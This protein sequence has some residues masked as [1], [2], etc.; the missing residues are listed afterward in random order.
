MIGLYPWAA[1]A[2]AGKEPVGPPFPGPPF[3]FPAFGDKVIG[4]DVAYGSDLVTRFEEFA[5]VNPIFVGDIPSLVIACGRSMG[6]GPFALLF[7][8]PDSSQHQAMPMFI[9]DAQNVF[10][11]IPPGRAFPQTYVVYLFSQG[12]I[13]QIGK[14]T[15]EVFSGNF[16]SALGQFTVLPG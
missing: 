3:V 11:W 10:A 2:T 15:V 9:Y 4:I 6:Q 8:K 14:W 1:I 16:A 5:Q 12:E 13:D 7:T